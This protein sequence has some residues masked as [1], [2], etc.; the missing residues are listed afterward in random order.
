MSG[1]E[2][3]VLKFYS[4]IYKPDRESGNDEKCRYSFSITVSETLLPAKIIP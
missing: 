2:T 3:T 4:D 1:E